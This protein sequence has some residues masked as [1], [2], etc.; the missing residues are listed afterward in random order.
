MPPLNPIAHLSVPLS[1]VFNSAKSY[2]GLTRHPV[3]VYPV[4]VGIVSGGVNAPSY[5]HDDD[6]F[7]IFSI[8]VFPLYQCNAIVFA[9]QSAVKFDAPEYV[10]NGT[11]LQSAVDVPDGIS[12][13]PN[14]GAEKIIEKIVKQIVPICFMLSN[15]LHVCVCVWV[16]VC[17]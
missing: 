14:V 10:S 16:C 15:K 11:F 7:G 9:C 6:A 3:N 13:V 4:L 5:S 1:L 8:N 17:V 12:D 2:V